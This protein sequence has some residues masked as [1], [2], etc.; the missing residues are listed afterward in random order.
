MV[1]DYSGFVA[2]ANRLITKY[3]RTLTFYERP[4]TDDASKPW[5]G[6]TTGANHADAIGVVIEESLTQVDGIPSRTE[7][8]KRLGNE[9][10]RGDQIC[11]TQLPPGTTDP[12]KYISLVD[13]L[14]STAWNI[15]SV[16]PIAPGPTVVVYRLHL[17]Q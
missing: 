9:V 1:K 5:R 12:T 17:R 13:S 2:L 8:Q 3:G 10:K 14:T 7:D 6:S 4:G 16:E 11:F 15:L